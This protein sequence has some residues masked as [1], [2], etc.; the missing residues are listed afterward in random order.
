VDRLDV[1]DGRLAEANEDIWSRGAVWVLAQF[2]L[3]ALALFAARLGP[4]LPQVAAGPARW[5]GAGLF[6][7]GGAL[8]L[9][10]ALAMGSRLTPFPKPNAE[11]RLVQSGPFALA[12]HPIYGGGVIAVLGWALFNG[13]WLGL[14]AAAGLGVFFD[15]KARLEERWLA[16]Q[17]P[18]YGGYRRRVRRLI[19]FVY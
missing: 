10:G 12:R 15:A 8:F 4:G 18:E 1:E 7:S 17:F 19:P 6:L 2:P 9:A 16:A 5:L 13:A 3:T 14:L 11:T